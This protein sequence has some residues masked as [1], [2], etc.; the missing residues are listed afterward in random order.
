MAAN[1]VRAGHRVTGYNRSRAAVDRLVSAGG[2][3]AAS[4]AEAVVDAD[5][6]ITLLPADAE[7][8]EVTEVRSPDDPPGLPT[9][10]RQPPQDQELARDADARRRAPPS[11]HPPQAEN[12]RAPHLDTRLASGAN[13]LSRVG[14]TP[15]PPD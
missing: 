12:Q 2:Q 14:P 3:S 15:A 13:R 7:V 10:A 6:V 9:R 1:L 4:I 8:T 11:P 5:A